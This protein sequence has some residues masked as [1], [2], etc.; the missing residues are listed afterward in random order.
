MNF[1]A[2]QFDAYWR[3]EVCGLPAVCSELESSVRAGERLKDALRALELSTGSV[4]RFSTFMVGVR[5][6]MKRDDK[7]ACFAATY[8]YQVY[9]YVLEV[10]NDE[11]NNEVCLRELLEKIALMPITVKG[12]GRFDF[13]RAV[14]VHDDGE[15]YLYVYNARYHV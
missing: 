13:W 2:R 8:N 5:E 7:F 14:D 3:V 1:R 6:R 9:A 4:Q 10:F 12:A 11:R 15:E